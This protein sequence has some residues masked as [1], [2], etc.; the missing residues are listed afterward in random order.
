MSVVKS[1]TCNKCVEACQRQPGWFAV[2]EAE[3]AASLFG[4]PFKEFREK[5]LILDHA[6]NQELDDAPYVWAP[7]KHGVDEPHQRIRT[8][9][10][11]HKE[12][13][14]VF[15][16][17][18]RCS[19]HEAKPQE[20]RT[21]LACEWVPWFLAA[22]ERNDVESTYMEAGYPLGRRINFG[23]DVENFEGAE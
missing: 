16:A 3:K 9:A 22:K 4:M 10:N 13:P 20:C 18:N 15:L 12:G 6:S 21:V 7:R 17:N 23:D 5:Y 11:Q 19:I 2:G 8:P 1:C 14:C